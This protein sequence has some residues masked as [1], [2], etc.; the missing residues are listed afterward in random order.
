MNYLKT[1]LFLSTIL[2]LACGQAKNDLAVK[3]VAAT[4]AAYTEQ[5]CVT[6]HGE[7]GEGGIGPSFKAGVAMSRSV[8][9]LAT[10]IGTGSGQMPSFKDKLSQEQI[11]EL[12]KYVYK[13]IQGR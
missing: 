13:E 2:A 1:L 12:A 8:D 5:K 9:D 3:D 11:Q 10:R 4:R 7:K 6:C